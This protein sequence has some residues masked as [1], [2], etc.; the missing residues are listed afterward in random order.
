MVAQAD[1]LRTRQMGMSC[2]FDDSFLSK[3]DENSRSVGSIAVFGAVFVRPRSASFS[4]FELLPTPKAQGRI[5]RD[6]SETSS[7][8]ENERYPSGLTGL[9]EEGPLGM[10]TKKKTKRFSVTSV[11]KSFLGCC[12]LRNSVR[13]EEADEPWLH[14]YDGNGTQG[15][16]EGGRTGA[17]DCGRSGATVDAKKEA[18]VKSETADALTA[19]IIASAPVNE[20]EYRVAQTATP[21]KSEIGARQVEKGFLL[22][23]PLHLDSD[24]PLL[25]LDLDE[26]LVHSTFMPTQA[27]LVLPIAL[28]GN[29]VSVY[30]GLR[31]F[32]SEFL[33]SM[34]RIYEIAIYTASLPSYADPVI[35]SIDPHRVVR[36][37]LFRDSCIYH[38]GSYVKVGRDADCRTSAC[39]D[40]RYIGRL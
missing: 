2:S 40:G 14:E 23:A 6:S 17:A 38:L 21:I 22:P 4:S 33:E 15:T 19:G 35:D 37:R 32:V 10:A 11:W 29:T 5:E 28:S 34:G 26:T 9:Q 13:D 16:C 24:R 36:H 27:D 3:I 12:F 7:D 31:P 20:G 18:S 8:E 39:W 25:V 1:G 30:V